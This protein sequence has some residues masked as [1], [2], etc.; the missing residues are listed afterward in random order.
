MCARC[1]SSGSCY[2]LALRNVFVFASRRSSVGVHGDV[3]LLV[4]AALE[5]Q[6]AAL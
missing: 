1:A 5:N 6:E 4:L 2:L 3:V